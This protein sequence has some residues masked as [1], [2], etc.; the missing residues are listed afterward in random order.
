MDG[1]VSL[2]DDDDYQ[3]VENLWVELTIG[4]ADINRDNIGPIIQFLSE[5]DFNWDITV[6]NIAFIH[7]DGTKQVLRS[8]LDF[9]K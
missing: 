9:G 6:N 1:I 5:R 7:D 4:F 3:L 8:R 2:L